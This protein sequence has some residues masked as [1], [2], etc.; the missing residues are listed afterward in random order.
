[1]THSSAACNTDRT[2]IVH[3]AIEPRRRRKVLRIRYPGNDA[4]MAIT[5]V[6]Q[7]PISAPDSFEDEIHDN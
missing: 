3:S 7:S 4:K 6:L 1:M 5:Q 2:E